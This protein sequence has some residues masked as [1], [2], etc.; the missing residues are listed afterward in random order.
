VLLAEHDPLARKAA[1]DALLKEHDFA[2][3]GEVTDGVE[4]VAT[5]VAVHP[6]VVLMGADLPGI[7]GI[8]ATRQIRDRAPAVRVVVFAIDEDFE[9]GLR[10]LE[11]GAA[12]FL[13]KDI[14]RSALARSLRGVS[15]GEAAISRR[16]ALRLI[17]QLQAA[18]DGRRAVRAARSQPTKRQRQVLD[19]LAQGR[20]T[21]DVAR[22][23]HVSPG[24]VRSH[25]ERIRHTLGART[26]AELI[27][28]AR[29]MRAAQTPGET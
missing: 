9:L 27:D 17:E 5:A 7:S 29:R 11:A 22:E 2:I 23:L 19:L 4:A 3:V 12:G 28:A 6:D 8:A 14:D 20:T 25:I 16:L 24:T 18:S 26:R 1:R 13:S 15:R 21:A 10:G